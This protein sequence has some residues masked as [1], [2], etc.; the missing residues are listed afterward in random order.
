MK[1]PTCVEQETK[2]CVYPGMGSVTMMGWQA[3]YDE[4]GM[5]HSHDPNWTTTGYRCSEGHYWQGIGQTACPNCIFGRE[6]EILRMTRTADGMEVPQC[7]VGYRIGKI[8]MCCIR[9]R[10]HDGNHADSNGTW[11]DA[12]EK[13]SADPVPT[14][15]DGG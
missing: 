11:N 8:L 9:E 7:D 5:Y 6:Q 13:A 15:T 4:D 14:G 10:G 3:Y 1:C 12:T 2:S